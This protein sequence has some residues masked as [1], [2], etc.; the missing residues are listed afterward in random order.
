[1]FEIGSSLREAR[2]R[3]GLTLA[4]AERETK[5]RQRYLAALEDERFGV[6]PGDAYARGFLRTY[7]EYLDLDGDLYVDEFGQRFSTPEEP[8]ALPPAALRSRRSFRGP[9]DRRLLVAAAVAAVL[10]G[11]FWLGGKGTER[12]T[13]APSPPPRA[14]PAAPAP[15]PQ[16]RVRQRRRP[17][18]A[19]TLTLVA[20]RGDCW[21]SVRAGSQEGRT[22]FESTL[23]AGKRLRF[24]L[25][26]PLWI[27][28]GAPW[29]LDATVRGA[30]VSLPS[31]TADVLVTASGVRVESSR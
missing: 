1:V 14:S 2:E 4:D 5:I 19:S 30:R 17:K 27:R 24:G 3:R 7:A 31:V 6:L 21:L 25:R 8:V 20:S 22:L 9:G 11:L 12:P 23:A 18:R 16:P 15:A 26:R 29:N 10:A 13:L 28:L